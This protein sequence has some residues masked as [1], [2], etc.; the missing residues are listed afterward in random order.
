MKKSQKNVR[1]AQIPR[2]SPPPLLKVVPSLEKL[3]QAVVARNDQTNLQPILNK[4][5]GGASLTISVTDC[6]KKLKRF[7]KVAY[8]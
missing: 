5:A 1:F 7:C 6:L 4:G 8:L 2:I 3:C